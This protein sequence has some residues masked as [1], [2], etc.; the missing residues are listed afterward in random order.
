[1]A[2]LSPQKDWFQNASMGE[3]LIDIHEKFIRGDSAGF[4]AD[5]AMVDWA[6]NKWLTLPKKERKKKRKTNKDPEK[7]AAAVSRDKKAAAKWKTAQAAKKK[8]IDVWQQQLESIFA[9][10]YAELDTT[11]EQAIW[12]RMYDETHNAKGYRT[13][14]P[15][16]Q[17]IGKATGKVAWGS[18]SEIGKAIN[19]L[20][21]PSFE[22]ITK[23]MGNK[24]KVRNFYNN[25]LSPNNQYGDVTIDTH[26]VAA[27][28]LRGLSG[29]S[30]EV[31]HNFGSSPAAGKRPADWVPAKNDN[32]T[33]AQGTYGIY[34]E[35]Y[36][37]AAVARGV[38]PREMQSI[39]WEAVRG[40]F[41]ASFKQQSSNVEAIDNVW[42]EYDNKTLTLKEARTKVLGIADGINKPEW[43]DARNRGDE[44]IGAASYDGE[45]SKI[46]VRR[47][48][49]GGRGD[50]GAGRPLGDQLEQRGTD[51]VGGG[52]VRE[53]VFTPANREHSKDAVASFE[54]G[55]VIFEELSPTGAARFHSAITEAVNGLGA[56]G[57]AVE[58]K[59]VADLAAGKMFLTPDGSMGVMIKTDGDITSV[60]KHATKGPRS[61][62]PKLI[63]IAIENGGTKL[64]AFDGFLPDS[65]AKMGFVADSRIR[66]SDTV[67]LTDGEVITVSPDGW[68]KKIMEYDGN[69][70]EPDVVFMR[71]DPE[72]ALEYS[73]EQGVLFP[74]YD[75]AAAHRDALLADGPKTTF[76][77]TMEDPAAY[78]GETTGPKGMFNRERTTYG[79]IKNVISLTNNAD[80]STFLHETGHFWLYQLTQMLNDP[81]LPERGRAIVQKQWETT[82]SWFEKN[83]EDAWRD[84]QLI[85][86]SAQKEA[87][88][89]PTDQT[90]QERS[91]QLNEAI[92]RAKLG[93]GHF[94]M[95]D[96][97]RGFMDGSVENGTALEIGFHEMWARGM[98]AYLFEGKSPSVTLKH[99]FSKF[100]VWLSGVYKNLKN[101]NVNLDADIRGVF[102]RVLATEE[103]IEAQRQAIEFQI[104]VEIREQI[105]EGEEK[106]L[107][108]LAADAQ[109]MASEQMQAKVAEDILRENTVEY[110]DRRRKATEKIKEEVR[111]EPLYRARNLILSGIF[112]DGTQMFTESGEPSNLKLS[113]EEFIS[114][115]GQ[116]K[117]NELPKGSF[118]K[119]GSKDFVPIHEVAQISGFDHPDA[120]VLALAAPHLSEAQ[121]IATR[122]NLA[123]QE[124]AE[125]LLN[126]NN[127]ADE[128]A[129]VVANDKQLELMAAQSRLL[130]RLARSTLNKAAQRTAEQEG[131]PAPTTDRD[132][133][134]DA[135]RGAGAQD[136]AD[137]IP[138]EIR[139]IQ[140]EEQQKANRPQLRAQRAATRR[141]AELTRGIDLATIKEAADRYVLKT[142]V[143]KLS[144]QKFRVT[145]QRLSKKIEKALAA[146]KYDEAAALMDQRTLNIA[147]AKRADTANVS[148]ARKVKRIRK[149]LNT[150]DKKLKNSRDIDI[151]NTLRIGLE[152]YALANFQRG[153]LDPRDALAYVEAE[154]KTYYTSLIGLANNMVADSIPYVEANPDA[155]Y[156]E[157]PY[158]SFVQLMNSADTLLANSRDA[159][160]M[161]VEG[162][163]IEIKSI[164]DDVRAR[165]SALNPLKDKGRGRGSPKERGRKSFGGSLK[166]ILT[167]VESWGKMIDNEDF[168]G[169][170]STYLIRPVMAAVDEY[171]TKREEPMRQLLA[172][173]VPVQGEL[174]KVTRI[175]APEL[176]DWVF[177]SKGEIISALLHTGNSSNMFRLLIGGQVH[178]DTKVKSAFGTEVLDEEGKPT[179]ELDDGNFKTFIDRMA[180]EGILTKADMDL[181]QGIWDIHENTKGAVQKAHKSMFGYHFTEIEA[182]PIMTPWGE[183]RGGYAPIVFDEQMDPDAIVNL[184][185]D[186]LATQA[187]ASIFPGASDGFTKAR[188]GAVARPLKLDITLVPAHFDKVM[189]FSY[190]G[191]AVHRAARLIK[192]KDFARSIN[193]YDMNVIPKAII[194]W[195]QRTVA[196]QVTQPTSYPEA[197]RFFRNLNSSV[198]LEAMT[199]NVV[200]SIQQLTGLA[201]AL[202]VV[203]PKYLGRARA[204]LKQTGE[205]GTEAI[206]R[207][208]PFMATRLQDGVRELARNIEDILKDNTSLKKIQYFA[209]KYGYLA[210]QMTQNM[211]D[212]IVWRAAEMQAVDEGLYQT[213]YDSYIHMGHDVAHTKG[214]AATAM[215]ADSIVRDT[216]SPMGAQDVSRFEAGTAFIRLFTKFTG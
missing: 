136:A 56:I 94:Y 165:V 183:Y 54:F 62:I 121:Q 163:R 145:A 132:I 208:S 18:F 70:G 27:A 148:Q 28:L 90:K 17:W 147:I 123:T 188:L 172:L 108:R 109:Q 211:I 158:E 199:G 97:A 38:E 34:A 57:A 204:E 44:E 50:T 169:P 40:L 12:L 65:Y 23:I 105:T 9:T 107:R 138:G 114:M 210:Q 209:E 29:N 39:T 49:A 91:R 128:A 154:N 73:E 16:G 2:A 30:P 153:N 10:P 155:A 192:N 124:D 130:R 201:T 53:R 185:A 194:P 178:T 171:N 106:S 1:M 77:Q 177:R 25:I 3:R 144:P 11:R 26:A 127:I 93:G 191:P 187:N 142:K 6:T 120:M 20:K 140:A 21:D 112:P 7:E 134:E 15:E 190:L 167:R 55:G 92:A 216:Q 35:A 164:A 131:A 86:K 74:D 197:D 170:I 160:T 33:G 14:T 68:D 139:I 60:F 152:P 116:E 179:G 135:Q 19:S 151:I 22:N 101:L 213:V 96:V 119:K 143:G 113:R 149:I 37:V 126:P 63:Q 146:R 42:K 89:N 122:V 76:E 157:M 195:L 180:R 175:Q 99:V 166:A 43:V 212:P 82:K 186:A 52:T 72:A 24:N 69:K 48:T 51:N 32:D 174:A 141:L 88:A 117:A 203:K 83:S 31:H 8:D 133:L 150:P 67:T 215:Y 79:D 95:K 129:E 118:L 202:V 125:S 196:Q 214:E 198:G 66:W 100:T 162:N 159:T 80:R 207:R 176:N 189:K 71:Y 46:R 85:S 58:I 184:D 205:S 168:N 75:A 137:A 59:D 64:D 181:V 182:E 98:E 111:E 156:K 36:R 78:Q 61:A 103:E 81:A 13:L 4:V 173:L 41:T 115:Y 193:E 87:E 102:D 104:P 110:K 5:Q 206:I 47:R 84:I 200:N 161:L 45:L